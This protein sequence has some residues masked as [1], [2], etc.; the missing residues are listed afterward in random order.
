METLLLRY[1][2]EIQYMKFIDQKNSDLVVSLSGT[3]AIFLKMS[4]KIRQI[5]PTANITFSEGNSFEYPGIYSVWSRAPYYDIVGYSHCKGLS[6]E[7]LI[8]DFAFQSVIVPWK[9]VVQIFSDYPSVDRVGFVA[10]SKGW[11]WF[12]F[13]WARANYIMNSPKPRKTQKYYYESYLGL[14]KDGM[15]CTKTEEGDCYTNTNNFYSLA[16]GAVSNGITSYHA[17]EVHHALFRKTANRD[18]YKLYQT[19]PND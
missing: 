19:I 12:N 18:Y 14:R 11:A 10:S 13:W 17:L 8:P 16:F 7:K 15:N 9:R 2:K 1:I 5:L 4:H 6:R 3:N